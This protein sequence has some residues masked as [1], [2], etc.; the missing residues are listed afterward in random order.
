MSDD[1]VDE[2]TAL[3]SPPPPDVDAGGGAVRV[4]VIEMQNRVEAEPADLAA[5]PGGAAAAS[6]S[7]CPMLF[8]RSA[9][10]WWNPQFD[11]N[12]L[13]TQHAATSFPQSRLRFR[14]ALDYIEIS[15][16]AWLTQFAIQQGP[17]WRAFV[18]GASCLLIAAVAAYTVCSPDT[19]LSGRLVLLA[20]PAYYAKRGLCTVSDCPSVCLSVPSIDRVVLVVL[21]YTSALH[22]C[23]LTHAAG[24]PQARDIDRQRW[25]TDGGRWAP[26]SNGAAAASAASATL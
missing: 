1:Q 16:A 4:D 26:S 3:K 23:F 10:N 21:Q 17:N 14:Y 24:R 22:T 7:R 25:A 8:Q 5:D 13:E 9:R 12:V 15:C 18:G 6:S 11:S 19:F 20:P 2:K